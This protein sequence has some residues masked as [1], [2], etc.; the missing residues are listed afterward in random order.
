MCQKNEKLMKIVNIEGKENFNDIF[1]KDV[2]YDILK[3]IKRQ[4]FTLIAQIATPSHSSLF[5]VH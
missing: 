1:Q 3:I 2:T 5:R 4:G